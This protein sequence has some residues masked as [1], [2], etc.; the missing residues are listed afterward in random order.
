MTIANLPHP[1]RVLL[2][3]LGQ[4]EFSQYGE[5]YGADLD[6]LVAAGLARIHDADENQETFI[7]KGRGEMY[8]AVSLTE[9]GRAALADEG[10]H[11]ATP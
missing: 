4:A 7:A 11:G 5:C 3:W 9:A 1:Q 6:A 10:D 2:R 8:R